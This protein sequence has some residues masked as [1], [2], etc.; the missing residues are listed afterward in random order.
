MFTSLIE[1]VKELVH[2]P[3]STTLRYVVRQHPL[4]GL[5][6]TFEDVTDALTMERSYNTLIAVQRETLD[7]LYEGVAEIGGDGRLRLSNPEFGKLCKILVENLDAVS[8]LSDIAES[9]RPLLG[10]EGDWEG[11][12]R[13]LIELLT[14]REFHSG[15]IERTDGSI[16]NYETMPLPDGAVLLIYLDVS[17]SINMERALRERAEALEAANRLLMLINDIFDL[18]TIEAGHM[19]L[20]LDSIDL[21]ELLNS[22]L[23]LVQERARQKKLRLEC[24]CPPDIGS[25]VADKRRLKQVL[26]NTLSNAVKFT[27]ENGHVTLSARRHDEEVVLT[28][29]DNGI[30]ITEEDRARVFDKLEQGESA[31]ARRSG[32]GLG[33]LLVRSFVEL[34][35]GNVGIESEPDAET[36][37]ICSPPSRKPAA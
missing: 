32:V 6:L 3:D 9:M 7:N 8:H 14:A 18:A 27:P 25:I 4:G 33:L 2:L 13:Q 26:F 17:A 36:R 5:I 24:D 1:P 31:E 29:E 30:G 35:G 22:S 16:L 10:D 34:H 12:K 37:I 15:T 11:T 28:T 23:G 20:E 19:T 21:S